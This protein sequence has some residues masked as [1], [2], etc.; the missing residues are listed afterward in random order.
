[1][2]AANKPEVPT[3]CIQ[4]SSNTL[5]YNTNTKE[6]YEVKEEKQKKE[7]KKKRQEKGK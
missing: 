1:M 2:K 6:K 5:L 7:K 3:R 4:G